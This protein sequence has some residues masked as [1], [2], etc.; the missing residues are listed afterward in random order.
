MKDEGSNRILNHERLM[1]PLILITYV[2]LPVI[3]EQAQSEHMQM[4]L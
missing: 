2:Y 1:N 4:P 3:S